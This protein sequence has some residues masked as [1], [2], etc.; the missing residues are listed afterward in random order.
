[1]KATRSLIGS[2]RGC[3]PIRDGTRL[4][5]IIHLVKPTN[6]DEDPQLL[7]VF[8]FFLS[9]SKTKRKE[10]PIASGQVAPDRPMVSVTSD[11]L[12]PGRRPIL[13]GTQLPLIVISSQANESRRGSS[14]QRLVL[15]FGEPQIEKYGAW[16]GRFF[17]CCCCCCCCCLEVDRRQ[18]APRSTCARLGD[19]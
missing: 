10:P 18:T 5:L 14:N 3:R 9:K 11:W 12:A 15:L 6:Q 1:M 8:L 7:L 17:R 13:E 4:P 19:Q 16:D 2:R